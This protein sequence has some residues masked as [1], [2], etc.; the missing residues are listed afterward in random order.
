MSDNAALLR[1]VAI[2]QAERDEALAKAE[3]FEELYEECQQE[4]VQ[5]RMDDQEKDLEIEKLEKQIDSSSTMD[6]K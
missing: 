1:L 2:L 3:H 6:H 4:L 5:A